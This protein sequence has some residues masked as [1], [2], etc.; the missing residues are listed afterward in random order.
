[1]LTR[2]L[3]YCYSQPALL[4]D[5]HKVRSSRTSFVLMHTADQPIPEAIEI[6]PLPSVLPPHLSFARLN[7]ST[8]HPLPFSSASTN[9]CSPLHLRHNPIQIARR[10]SR[11][12]RRRPGANTTLFT[13]ASNTLVLGHNTARSVLLPKT[14]KDLNLAVIYLV[15]IV[16]PVIAL[17]CIAIDVRIVRVDDYVFVRYQKFSIA[18]VLA[19]VEA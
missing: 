3:Y 11:H 16:T 15:L 13:T 18:A 1:M 19:D 4:N 14:H 9:L 8:S 17:D 6:S 5:N 10:R 12:C 7:F 2:N